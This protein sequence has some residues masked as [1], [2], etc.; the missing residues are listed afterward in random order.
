MFSVK[1]ENNEIRLQKRE[2]TKN[3]DRIF[4]LCGGENLK[5]M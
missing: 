2:N 1:Y 3:Y 4:S 5:N